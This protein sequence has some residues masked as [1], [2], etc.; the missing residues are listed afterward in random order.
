MIENSE[1][2]DSN[3]RSISSDSNLRKR[4]LKSN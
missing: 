2:Y 4:G 1:K 3:N